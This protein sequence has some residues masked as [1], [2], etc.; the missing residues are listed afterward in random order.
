MKGHRR[1]PSERTK[2]FTV[3]GNGSQL[4]PWQ[5]RRSTGKLRLLAGGNHSGHLLVGEGGFV[6]AELTVNSAV[7]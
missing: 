1:G 2:D 5:K 7:Y 3:A 4:F 6:Y